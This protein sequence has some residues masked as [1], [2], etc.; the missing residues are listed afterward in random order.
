LKYHIGQ[1]SIPDH[2]D[3]MDIDSVMTVAGGVTTLMSMKTQSVRA[4]YYH[5]G[6]IDRPTPIVS[7]QGLLS[8]VL[9]KDSTN[10]TCQHF[11]PDVDSITVTYR[12]TDGGASV[13]LVVGIAALAGL[14]IFFSL[15][16]QMPSE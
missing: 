1:K 14:G 5:N 13:L 7:D 16:S 2:L 9:Q 15:V 4:I 6:V 11:V 10:E 8:V 3:Y 12:R